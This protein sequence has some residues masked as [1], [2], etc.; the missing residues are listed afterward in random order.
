MLNIEQEQYTPKSFSSRAGA[1]LTIHG[2]KSTATPETEGINLMPYTSSTIGIRQVND[3]IY[4]MITES[5]SIN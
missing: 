2:T 5:C 3:F 1:K 4:N